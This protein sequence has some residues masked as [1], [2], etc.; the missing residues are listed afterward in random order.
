VSCRGRNIEDSYER[1]R[2]DGV[3]PPRT[4][5]A[6][7]VRDSQKDRYSSNQR[8]PPPI[9][10][11][12]SRLVGADGGWSGLSCRVARVRNW[13]QL[14]DRKIRDGSSSHRAQRT[15]ICHRVHCV[16]GRARPRRSRHHPLHR[17]NVAHTLRVEDRRPTSMHH[18]RHWEGDLESLARFG[19]RE[20][21]AAGSSAHANSQVDQ[22]TKELTAAVGAGAQGWLGAGQGREPRRTDCARRCCLGGRKAGVGGQRLLVRSP[23]GPE[24]AGEIFSMRHASGRSD[25]TRNECAKLIPIRFIWR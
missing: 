16:C 12:R 22:V 19:R 4:D 23:A 18:H 11:A 1:P 10:F 17:G 21:S 25:F 20:A 24:K 5:R 3:L 9:N 7:L 14:L 6:F 8:A 2:G 13:R 15:R